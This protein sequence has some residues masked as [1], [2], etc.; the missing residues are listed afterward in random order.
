MIRSSDERIKVAAAKAILDRLIS[1]KE[2][3]DLE[4]RLATL[5]HTI[6][7]SQTRTNAPPP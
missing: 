7:D 5:E 1:L 2:F 6:H 3:A 4:E